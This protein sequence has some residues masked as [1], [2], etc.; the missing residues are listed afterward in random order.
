MFPVTEKYIKREYTISG[1]HL[2]LL[3]NKQISDIN[4]KAKRILFFIMKKVKLHNKQPDVLNIYQ[5]LLGF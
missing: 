1:I 5:K 2:I 3:D 4:K